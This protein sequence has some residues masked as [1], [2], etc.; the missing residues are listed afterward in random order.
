ME[1]RC[2]HCFVCHQ[3]ALHCNG[4]KRQRHLFSRR[5]CLLC[6]STPL[7]PFGSNT[8]PHTRNKHQ[9]NHYYRSHSS[10]VSIPSPTFHGH[11]QR[12][13]ALPPLTHY[14]DLQQS[15]WHC[16]SPS[17]SQSNVFIPQN[18]PGPG[19][20]LFCPPCQCHARYNVTLLPCNQ[21][22]PAP[23]PCSSPPSPKCLQYSELVT[24]SQH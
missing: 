7:F 18:L 24:T 21:C 12:P 13:Y 3:S 6:A 9:A 14:I 22:H 2:S 8:S 19:Y 5:I 11:R 10:I 20:V 4:R 23:T 1:P 17:Q 15:C 16:P